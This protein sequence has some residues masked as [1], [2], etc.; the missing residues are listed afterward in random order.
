[1]IFIVCQN[2]A[3]GKDAERRLCELWVNKKANILHYAP[4]PR[5]KK[6]GHKSKKAF[7]PASDGHLRYIALFEETIHHP[8]LFFSSFSI[9]Q[10]WFNAEKVDS[11]PAN[12]KMCL[13]R[14]ES[15]MLNANA[16]ISASPKR[17]NRSIDWRS[18][19]VM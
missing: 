17:A 15:L 19:D 16:D 18:V 10:T 3:K 2:H 5:A 1:M 6:D 12:N 9:N 4:K 7:F 13:S 14:K 11:Q 8:P